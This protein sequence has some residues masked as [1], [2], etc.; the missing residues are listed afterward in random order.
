[1]GC[2]LRKVGKREA[3]PTLGATSDQTMVSM[4]AKKIADDSQNFHVFDD[5]SNSH[6][7]IYGQ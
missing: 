2:G 4:P 5:R 6:F 3:I 7:L 1:M